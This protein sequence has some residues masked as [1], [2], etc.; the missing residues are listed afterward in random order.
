MPIHIGEIIK[1]RVEHLGLTQ[2]QF[3]ALINKHEKTVP[4]IYGRPTMSIDLLIAI[5]EAL[6]QDFLTV[7]YG[8]E[9][10]QSLREDQITK[11]QQ[12]VKTLTEKAELLAKELAWKQELIDIQKG[13]L[14]LAIERLG[15]IN[16]VLINSRAEV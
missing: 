14:S 16:N 5:S 8:E 3:G 4:D 1:A 11:L 2:K 13:Y 9:P 15:T 10:L 12:Q 7:Y 6:K